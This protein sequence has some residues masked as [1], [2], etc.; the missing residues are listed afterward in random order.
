MIPCNDAIEPH[1]SLCRGRPWIL[2]LL[3]ALAYLTP[4]LSLL[5][6]YGPTWDC[7]QGELPYGERLLEYIHTGDERFL[8]LLS[9]EPEPPVRQPHPD[10]SVRRFESHQVFPVAGLLSAASC[11]LLWTRWNAVPAMVAHHA[12]IVFLSAAVVFA[13]TAFAARRFGSLCGVVSGASLALLP[14][15]F[16][17]SFNNLKDIPECSFYTFAIL[18]F[19]I[20]MERNG[21]PGVTGRSRL[22]WWAVAGAFTGLALAQKPNA[23]FI[24]VQML[25][26]WI[27]LRVLSRG[28][29]TSGP[30]LR[31]LAFAGLS[32]LATYYGASPAFW[33]APIEGPIQWIREMLRIGNLA[34]DERAQLAPWWLKISLAA[35]LL[36]LVTTPPI[37]LVLSALGAFHPRLSANQ[38]L[39]LLLG[40]AIPVGRNLIPGMRNMDGIR[41]FLEF[42]PMLSILAGLGA[43]LLYDALQTRTGARVRT[44]RAAAI[45]LGITAILPS[46]IQTIRTHPNGIAYFNGLIGGLPGA[47]A[48]N[49]PQ[50][51]DYWGNSYWQG[52]A[53]LNE[54]AERNALLLVP[55]GGH[56]ARAAAPVRLRGDIQF[57]SPGRSPESSPLYVMYV[58]RQEFYGPFLRALQ[59]RS[60]AVHEI[61]VQG[62]AI[63]RIHRLDGD[64]PS[65]EL[66]EIW[67][68]ED[69]ANRAFKRIAAHLARDSASMAGGVLFRVRALGPEGALE[70]FRPLLPEELHPDLEEVVWMVFAD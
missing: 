38:R 61:C 39:F 2:A 25:L 47:Q 10:F 13:V 58:T 15:F 26:F 6:Q 7:V 9:R 67:L 48:M 46:G 62:G 4:A 19:Y 18:S 44:L 68:R 41:H 63:L 23:L 42:L 11:R 57:W 17:D 59:R 69:R 50:A 40:V 43:S 8:D 5:P 20:A 49:V 60:S 51:T 28:R 65:L 45:G 1:R 22:R 34:F 55:V 64:P 32:F 53:W 29:E 66:Y 54:H 33:T 16:A 12:V 14:R 36:V 30:P 24:P 37:T 56:I 3:V 35:P 27:G 31:G 52:S 21:A 70:K